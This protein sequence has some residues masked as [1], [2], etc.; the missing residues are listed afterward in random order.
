M[1]LNVALLRDSFRKLAPQADR[2]ADVF[3]DTLF[4]Q[5]PAVK[6][7]FAGVSLPEQNKK[8]MA[9][10]GLVVKN[11]EKP[12]VLKKH[13]GQLGE[14]HVAY[15]ATAAHYPAAGEC[16]LAALEEV[17]GSQWTPELRK[18]WAGAYG[19]V[20]DLM[21]VGARQSTKEPSNPSKHGGGQQTMATMSKTTPKTNGRSAHGYG[22]NGKAAAGAAGLLSRVETLHG[23]L[24][25]LGTNVLVADAD[26]TLV[27][28]NRRSHETLR[29]IEPIVKEVLGLRV[30]EMV[31]QSLDRF[32][33][34]R[35][36]EISRLL[37]DR[38]RFPHRATISLGPKRLD[39]NVSLV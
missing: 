35:A 36:Q 8:L 21:R 9:A 39:L 1:A 33:G 19:A 12:D 32:H 17:A 22:G 10:L 26:L 25:N 14:R 34:A 7:L 2:L 16:L 23:A 28:L 3:Y 11:L 13:L 31:G 4:E 5:Y 29:A 24:E 37:G 27:Y 20:A 15:G 6:P 30:D 38:R 18:A